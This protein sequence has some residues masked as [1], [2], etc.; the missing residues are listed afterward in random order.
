L[1]EPIIKPTPGW[2]LH[3]STPT[4]TGVALAA[5]AVKPTDAAPTSAP[6][7]AGKIEHFMKIYSL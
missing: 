1:L 4:C 2:T 7:T 6:R 5:V 3:S